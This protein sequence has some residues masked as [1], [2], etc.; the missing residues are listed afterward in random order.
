MTIQSSESGHSG[1]PDP[2][3]LDYARAP[4]VLS[5][6]AIL[7]RTLLAAVAG[8]LGLLGVGAVVIPTI[9]MNTAKITPSSTDIGDVIATGI[10]G[11]SLIFVSLLWLGEIFRHPD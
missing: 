6:R 4:R 1:A 8:F 10:I 3:V 5:A 9:G 2:S 11:F 7:T